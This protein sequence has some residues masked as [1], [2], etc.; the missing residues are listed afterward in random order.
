MVVNSP[1]GAVPRKVEFLGIRLMCAM[2]ACSIIC[3]SC[4]HESVEKNDP[5]HVQ[6]ARDMAEGFYT[7]VRQAE[8][9]EAASLFGGPLS[10]DKGLRALNT[11]DSVRGGMISASIDSVFTEVRLSNARATEIEYDVY[12]DCHYERGGS[13]ES[14]II[15]GQDFDS[16]RITGYHF[17]AK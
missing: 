2:V 1:F 8:Y 12:L 7:H 4:D 10:L 13:L 9:Q 14:L 17:T 15:S 5:A 16:L 11:I 3:S 6:M